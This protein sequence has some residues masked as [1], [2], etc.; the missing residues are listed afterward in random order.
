MAQIALSS[1]AP[2][3]EFRFSLGTHEFT[4]GPGQVVDTDDESLAAE[5]SAHAFLAV[6]HEDAPAAAAVADTYN[7]FADADEE[8]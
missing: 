1:D 4:I 2:Q 7:L 5:A 6:T 8:N 3:E